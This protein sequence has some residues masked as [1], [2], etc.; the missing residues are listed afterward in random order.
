MIGANH[1]L[2]TTMSAIQLCYRLLSGKMISPAAGVMDLYFASFSNLKIIGCFLHASM[3]LPILHLYQNRQFHF[4][5]CFIFYSQ[6][7]RF[8]VWHSSDSI[9][10]SLFVCFKILIYVYKIRKIAIGS[11]YASYKFTQFLIS[12]KSTMKYVTHICDFKYWPI[13]CISASL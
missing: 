1:F 13:K 4:I 6:L 8:G 7:K 12:I 3:I 2:S 9:Q 11:I 5:L 10:N